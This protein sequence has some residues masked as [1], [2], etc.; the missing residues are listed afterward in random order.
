MKQRIVL[1]YDGTPEA[2]DAIAWL[3][4][5]HDADVVTLT[6]DLGGGAP[7]D[8]LRDLSLG[9][10]ALRA[11]VLDVQEEFAREIVVPAART[12]AWGPGRSVPALVAPLLARKLV[13]VARI[14][15]AA[16]VA[17]VP[18][19]DE[20]ALVASLAVL[21]PDL[22]ILPVDTAVATVGPGSHSVASSRKAVAGSSA[23][24][25]PAQVDLSFADGVPTTINGIAMRLPE[26]LESLATIATGHGLP[27]AEHVFMPA[28]AVLHAAYAALAP[29]RTG[30]VRLKLSDGRCHIEE[31][32]TA[33][34]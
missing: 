27:A 33:R 34:A 20:G 5:Q 2:A 29:A 17:Y 19:D 22:T 25:V 15:K 13:D 28:A 1:A 7:L 24:S 10:G 16:A 8:G 30:T 11:H 6:L 12:G 14:E 26:L 32:A 31:S 21:E 23:A 3:A 4:R 9:R 18:Q